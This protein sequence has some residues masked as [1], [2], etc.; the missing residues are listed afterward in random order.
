MKPLNEIT[1]WLHILIITLAMWSQGRI[2]AVFKKL[3]LTNFTLV[4]TVILATIGILLADRFTILMI[5]KSR[6]VRRLIS[7]SN[8][9]EGDWVGVVVDRTQ[10][11]V[12]IK[13]EYTRIRF[14]RGQHILSS[15]TWSMDGKW[16]GDFIAEG[17]SYSGRNFEFFFETGVDRAGG[18]GIRKF[19]PHDSIPTNWTG[20]FI[21]ER[22]RTPFLTRGR[23]IDFRLRRVD[24]S[25]RRELALEFARNFDDNNLP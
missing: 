10:P 22:W 14:Q 25:K 1:R 23:R 21:D 4:G 9:I 2:E 8:D 3:E 6:R 20:R 16:E 12:V 11:D 15:D 5:D 7:G 24:L 18:F 17:V 13:A 19:F